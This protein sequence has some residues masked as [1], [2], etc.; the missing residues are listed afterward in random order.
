M[1]AH[2][3]R[4]GPQR[5]VGKARGNYQKGWIGTLLEVVQHFAPSAL[6]NIALG[7]HNPH[8]IGFPRFRAPP[9]ASG[10]TAACSRSP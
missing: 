6:L 9:G 4:F 7:N 8:G 2:V 1:S 3:Q 10:H 5:F